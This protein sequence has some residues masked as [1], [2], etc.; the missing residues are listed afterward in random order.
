MPTAKKTAATPP[1]ARKAASAQP[2]ATALLKADH[3]RVALDAALSRLSGRGGG[4][5][6]RAQGSGNANGLE[7]ALAAAVHSLE[8]F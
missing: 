6:V 3:Q 8:P 1:A 4:N 7:D 5:A 2:D